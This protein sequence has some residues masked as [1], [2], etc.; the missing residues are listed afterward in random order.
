MMAREAYHNP[1]I[2]HESDGP[3]AGS[4]SQNCVCTICPPGALRQHVSNEVVLWQLTGALGE[5]VT[6]LPTAKPAPTAQ[7]N[8]DRAAIVDMV[9]YARTLTGRRRY[10]FGISFG[11]VRRLTLNCQLRQGGSARLYSCVLSTHVP[12]IPLVWVESTI[13]VGSWLSDIS[14]VA[15]YQLNVVGGRF[16]NG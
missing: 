14:V 2:V 12:Y 6:E 8:K 9:G 16:V 1:W 5:Q 4:V 10:Y 3:T 11:A 15:S 7:S 13:A